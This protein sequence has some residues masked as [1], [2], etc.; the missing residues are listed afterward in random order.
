MKIQV[1]SNYLSINK[2]TYK[3]VQATTFPDEQTS[4]I[5]PGAAEVF[6]AQSPDNRSSLLCLE[7]HGSGSGEADRHQ[8][9]LLLID[10]LGHKPVFLRLPGLLSSCR[11][12]LV[13]HNGQIA[14][15]KNRYVWN[16]AQD[17]RTGLQI[18]YFTFERGQFNATNKKINLRF[19][20]PENP[21]VF[22][23]QE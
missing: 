8:Q 15:P 1:A 12:V 13:T 22:Y 17:A 23:R 20:K 19:V 21:F 4:D 7:G 10:P 14:F 11:A 16:A 18:S 2:K 3:F 9:I 5:Y 6:I